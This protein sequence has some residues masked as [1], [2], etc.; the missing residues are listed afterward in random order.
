M[1]RLIPGRPFGA[2]KVSQLQW[3]KRVDIA[4]DR[5]ILMTDIKDESAY[6]ILAQLFEIIYT[7]W[8]KSA[9]QGSWR[10][11]AD[12]KLGVKLMCDWYQLRFCVI[13]WP[14]IVVV[15]GRCFTW[16]VDVFL[17]SSTKLTRS[18]KD[19]H[20]PCRDQPITWSMVLSQIVEFSGLRQQHKAYS[21]K[22]EK[23]VAILQCYVACIYSASG[24]DLPTVTAPQALSGWT[25]RQFTT[26]TIYHFN[27]PPN[28]P[29]TSPLPGSIPHLNLT[30]PTLRICPYHSSAVPTLHFNSPLARP[31]LGM[32][33]RTKSRVGSLVSRSASLPFILEADKTCVNS[34]FKTPT[35]PYRHQQATHLSFRAIRYTLSRDFRLNLGRNIDQIDRRTLL[36]LIFAASDFACHRP[37]SMHLERAI[38]QPQRDQKTLTQDAL[39][40][41]PQHHSP[42]ALQR[43]LLPA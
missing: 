27:P 31:Q 3:E 36:G 11:S 5:Q 23:S 6:Y 14:S 9:C 30:L 8:G 38:A 28:N 42:V 7:T 43:H 17:G 39:D 40:T 26:L 21:D 20:L 1:H 33:T 24:P 25:H 12:R 19:P 13:N 35:L 29:V 41:R 37:L 22:L 15:Q 2:H 4:S 16:E 32:G 34:A 18:R 10:G